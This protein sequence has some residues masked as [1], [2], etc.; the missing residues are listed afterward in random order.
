MSAR[1]VVTIVSFNSAQCLR[2]CLDSLKSQIY[3]DFTVALWDNASTDDTRAIIAAYRKFLGFV[4]LSDANLGFCSAHNRL[5]ES[6]ASDYVLVLNPDVVLESHFLEKLIGEMDLDSSAGSATGKLFR[7]TTPAADGGPGPGRLLDS[8]GLYFTPSQ[9]HFDRGSN[10]PDNGQYEKPEYVF[11]A[12]GAAALYRRTMLE[13]IRLEN[14]YFDECFFAYREDADL[15]WRAQWM[16]WRCRYVPS[17]VAYHIRK[18]LPQNRATLPDVIN[19]HSFKNRFLLRVK[20]MD[21]GTYIRFLLPIT[22]RDLAAF[23]YVLLREH[24]SFPA[25]P[26]LIRALPRAC[27]WRRSIK[28]GRRTSAAEMRSWFSYTPVAR[29]IP[30]KSGR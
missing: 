15:A 25:I 24:S 13:D 28:A 16:G 17:A 22:L 1:A 9:R 27:I 10:E 18:V 7:Q 3:R 2:A 20:N 23:L 12:S 5:I 21:A 8:T 14:E 4:H 26:L 29:R 6:S 30:E 19:L 11:G